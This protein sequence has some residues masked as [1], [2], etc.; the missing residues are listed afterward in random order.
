VFDDIWLIFF[1]VFNFFIDSGEYIGDWLVIV[2]PDPV[3]ERVTRLD[4]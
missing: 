3:E 4:I 1:Q 2:T